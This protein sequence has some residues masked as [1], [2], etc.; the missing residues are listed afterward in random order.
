SGTTVAERDERRVGSPRRRRGPELRGHY[1]GASE[2][3]V[4]AVGGGGGQPADG[5]LVVVVV[6]PESASGGGHQP[7]DSG[8]A[9]SGGCITHAHAR[10]P[11]LARRKH[12]DHAVR[13]H[14]LEI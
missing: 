14:L 7:A 1:S 9:A 6:E 3:G 5:N 11:A 12:D 2:R 13:R 10:R 4:V 8:D